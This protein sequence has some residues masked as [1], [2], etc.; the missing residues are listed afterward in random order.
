[1]TD[2]V[3]KSEQKLVRAFGNVTDIIVDN[4]KKLKTDEGDTKKLKELTT[5][6][7]ELYGIVKDTGETAGAD[8]NGIDVIFLGESDKWAE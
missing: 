8:K 3:K 1:M 7:K 2:K 5:I 4:A 6:A